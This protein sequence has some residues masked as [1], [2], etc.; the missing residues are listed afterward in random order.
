MFSSISV[1]LSV[2]LSHSI[3]D[4]LSISLSSDDDEASEEDVRARDV[5]GEVAKP[6]AVLKAN[7]S[8]P[9]SDVSVDVDDEIKA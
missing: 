3:F 8:R 2:S 6:Q 9:E 7:E 5:D 4:S 1:C